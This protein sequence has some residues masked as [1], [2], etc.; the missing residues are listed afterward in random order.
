LRRTPLVV[1]LLGFGRLPFHA[2]LRQHFTCRTAKPGRSR[3]QRLTREPRNECTAVNAVA[4]RHQALVAHHTAQC[5]QY[6]GFAA[7][8][9]EF[10]CEEYC[11]PDPDVAAAWPRACEVFG[12]FIEAYIA[13]IGFDKQLDWALPNMQAPDEV[14]SAPLC[15]P[16]PVQAAIQR[17]LGQQ[18]A[19]QRLVSFILDLL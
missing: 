2:E 3:E 7:E 17:M 11:Q 6:L 14:G 4:K 13:V 12:D 15:A 5:A 1:S 16:T 10:A 18:N 9:G 8:I 19:Y